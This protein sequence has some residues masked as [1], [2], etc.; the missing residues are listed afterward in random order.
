MSIGRRTLF[1]LAGGIAASAGLAGCTPGADPVWTPTPSA[2]PAPSGP[3]PEVSLWH[4][5]YP[6]E[7]LADAVQRW[8]ARY[9]AARVTATQFG[10]DYAQRTATALATPDGPDVFE[11]AGGPTPELIAAGRVADLTEVVGD[12]RA[13]FGE[14]LLKRLTHRDKLWAV[15]QAIDTA[16]LYYRRSLL[17]RAGIKPPRT[18]DELTAAATA[19]RAPGVAGLYAGPDGGL[20]ALGG[21]LVWA[22]GLDQITADGTTPAFAGPALHAAAAS[23]RDLVAAAGPADGPPWTDATPFIENRAAMQWSSLAEIDRVLAAHAGDF[24]VLPFPAAGPGGRQVVPVWASCACVSARARDLAAARAWVRAVWLDDHA[25]Q[26][27]FAG[28]YGA[29]VPARSRLVPQV[30]RLAA[31]VGADVARYVVELGQVD[32]LFWTPACADAFATALARVVRDGRDARS[33]FASAA[34]TVTDEIRRLS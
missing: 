29:H 18:L 6:D 10:A 24:G 28:A 19:L 20:A 30:A 13:E 8:A 17:T 4:P 25:K 15:P 14:R 34:A 32:H 5:A 7:G 23:F 22:S 31:G 27:E 2:P 1:A 11:C 9:P 16:V 12:R 21:L 26:I 33:E 3:L